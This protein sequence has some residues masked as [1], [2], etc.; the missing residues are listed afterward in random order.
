MCDMTAQNVPQHGTKR[1]LDLC[2][3]GRH[4]ITAQ[5]STR[6]ERLIKIISTRYLLGIKEINKYLVDMILINSFRSDIH[7]ITVQYSAVFEIPDNELFPRS[8]SALFSQFL[9]LANQKKKSRVF[10]HADEARKFYISH[11]IVYNP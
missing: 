10:F 11:S 5:Y 3:T 8:F 6:P 9:A 2:A 4:T 1:L 7:Y